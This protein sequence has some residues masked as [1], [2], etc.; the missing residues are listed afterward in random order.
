MHVA[1]ANVAILL[2]CIHTWKKCIRIITILDKKI[3]EELLGFTL[4][5]FYQLLPEE[6]FTTAHELGKPARKPRVAS[7]LFQLYI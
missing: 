2:L 6:K 4:H 5:P 7:H 3:N 1:Q